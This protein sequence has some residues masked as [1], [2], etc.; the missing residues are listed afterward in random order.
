MSTRYLQIIKTAWK[1]LRRM[2]VIDKMQV[3]RAHYP[4]DCGPIFPRIHGTEV[5]AIAS[6]SAI[7]VNA[8][9]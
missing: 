4:S 2:P 7:A 8:A 3:P 6:R 5:A 1:N 9:A